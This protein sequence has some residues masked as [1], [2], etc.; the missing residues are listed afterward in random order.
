MHKTKRSPDYTLI[1]IIGI[2]VVFGLAMLSSATAPFAYQKFEGDSYWFVK[3]Q[4]LHGLLPGLVLFLLLMRLDYRKLK[5]LALPMLFVNIVLLILV[6]VPSLGASYGTA[7]SWLVIGGFSIQPSE[8]V[9]LTFLIYLALWLER[10]AGGAV[11]NFYYSFLPFLFW[12]GLVAL[13][14]ALQPDTGTSFVFVIMAVMVYFLAR[15]KI[16]HLLSVIVIA[17]GG[18][19]ILVKQ[20]PYRMERLTV[21]LHPE[22]DPQGIGYHINQALL[23]V[24]SGGF[25]G[26]GFG[27]SRQKFQ[28]LPEIAG[29]SI[30]AVIAEELG[31]LF[32]FALVALFLYLLYR[33]FRVAQRAPDEF[34]KF[35]AA[36]IVCWF[37]M[38]AF[39]NIAAMLGLM[40]MTGIPFPFISYGGTALMATLAGAGVLVSISRHS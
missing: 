9:K 30:F 40:P 19:M 3:H 6:F 10:R 29:D 24:G 33:G 39:L 2:L 11:K 5:P 12:L 14:I 26:R 18:L 7:K 27:Q 28:Y 25:F 16:S 31:F 20:A 35:L 22:L 36:G 32:S 21:F 15:G 34:G 1:A 37:V 23:A 8:L 4:I 38:Q 17:V 13:L